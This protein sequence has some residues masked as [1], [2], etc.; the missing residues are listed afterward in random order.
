VEQERV[1]LFISCSLS[2]AKAENNKSSLFVSI[3]I[4]IIEFVQDMG[5]VLSSVCFISFP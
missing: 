2:L 1:K 5:V 4:E 3:R